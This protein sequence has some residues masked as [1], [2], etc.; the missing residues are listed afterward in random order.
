M[1]KIPGILCS[2]AAC[3]ALLT[4]EAAI[5]T[6]TLTY[7]QLGGSSFGSGSLELDSA[8][9]TPDAS[10]FT[11]THP[12]LQNFEATFWGIPGQSPLTFDLSRIVTV[13]I[14]TD[15]A[16]EIAD[17]NV[18]TY[19]RIAENSNTC[20]S[21]LE[22]YLA[23]TNI[24]VA[25]VNIPGL[26]EPYAYNVTLTAVPEPAAMALLGCGALILGIGLVRQK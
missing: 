25:T 8:I 9:L 13:F 10:V 11:N 7:Q 24:F 3:S 16:S 12:F 14:R 22:P 4:A 5:N 21:C 18:W 2:I 20:S 6:Y 15:F 23:G 1:K 26:N 17:F 19:D